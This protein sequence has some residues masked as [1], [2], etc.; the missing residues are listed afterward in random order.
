LDGVL[1]RSIE[2]DPIDSSY[3]SVQYCVI[4][5]LTEHSDIDIMPHSETN[6]APAPKGTISEADSSV[7]LGDYGGMYLRPSGMIWVNTQ[8]GAYFSHYEHQ[9]LPT[10]NTCTLPFAV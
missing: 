7:D 10:V 5:V 1:L 9:I 6:W 4:M 2:A 3:N 8:G